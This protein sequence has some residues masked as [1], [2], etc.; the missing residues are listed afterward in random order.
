MFVQLA[1]FE[2]TLFMDF[3]IYNFFFNLRVLKV[4]LQKLFI[5]KLQMV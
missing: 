4:I 5:I 2:K 1:E 3:N